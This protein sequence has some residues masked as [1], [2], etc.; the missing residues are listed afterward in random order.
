M[1]IGEHC[2][3]C[4]QLDFLPFRCSCK[5]AFCTQ[6]K[7]PESHNCVQLS[8]ALLPPNGLRGGF[9]VSSLKRDTSAGSSP[10][11]H[12]LFPDRSITI[13]LK[14]TQDHPTTLRGQMEKKA[15][16][17]SKKNMNALDKLKKFFAKNRRKRAL[18]DAVSV[19]S[20]NSSN[21][22]GQKSSTKPVTAKSKAAKRVV[23]VNK[24]RKTAKG[25]NLINL[26]DRLYLWVVVIDEESA[27]GKAQRNPVY[28][29][30]K[31]PIG[32]ALDDI[33]KKLEVRNVNNKTVDQK[34]RLFLFKVEP[35]LGVDGIE[36]NNYVRLELNERCNQR[37]KDGE[38]V[39]L[40]R[41]S[42]EV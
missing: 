14:T 33:A 34:E 16:E 9:D 1:D 29:G 25:H 26:V 37:L 42:S 23:E 27:F 24:L 39:Y 13:D 31:F 18:S 11:A 2:S 5:L 21:S 15:Q 36:A 41:G 38:V 35:E 10:T 12:S 4:G 3:L 40:V 22:T 19:I 6:H 30:K 28:V 32:R 20:S 17:G 8:Q 7:A